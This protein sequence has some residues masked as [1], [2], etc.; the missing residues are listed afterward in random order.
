MSLYNASV[1]KTFLISEDQND[2][3]KRF[4][5]RRKIS[6]SQYFR[7]II[8]QIRFTSDLDTV[9]KS[10]ENN[11]FSVNHLL[12]AYDNKEPIRTTVSDGNG[13]KQARWYKSFPWSKNVF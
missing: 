9:S 4:C 1:K 8:D 7:L 11:A 2:L 5:K 10:V 12:G 6:A 13:S 3:L